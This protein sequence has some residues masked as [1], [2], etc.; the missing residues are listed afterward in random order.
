MKWAVP[1]F[2]FLNAA[3]SNGVAAQ[4]VGQTS[5][6]FIENKLGSR[7][8][9]SE[10]VVS[11]ER[12]NGD[13]YRLHWASRQ[14]GKTLS[15]VFPAAVP[16]DF[17]ILSFNAKKYCGQEIY[18][19]TLRYDIP[20]TADIRQYFFET[21]AFL[22]S[23]FEYLASINGDYYD[24]APQAV[25]VDIGFP[26]EMPQAFGVVCSAES[27]GREYSFS[28]VQGPFALGQ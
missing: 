1:I 10:V 4:D 28:F 24:I 20:K 22:A 14:T 8:E 23:S 12:V 26:Y 6:S 18:F 3:A 19:V 9:T 27:D 13:E 7:I 5:Y 21:H 2:F 25:G 15:A 11:V 17:Q 16:V